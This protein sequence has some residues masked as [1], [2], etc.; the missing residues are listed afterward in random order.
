MS[1]LI[2][3]TIALFAV[4]LASLFYL[5]RS[6]KAAKSE[7]KESAESFAAIVAEIVSDNKDLRD[8]LFAKHALPPSGIDLS[9]QYRENAERTR[10]ELGERFDNV[11]DVSRNPLA[12]ARLRALEKQG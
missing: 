6:A 10:K 9:V 3:F 2:I 5:E 12:E 11:R 7:R 1:T 4:F 8:R